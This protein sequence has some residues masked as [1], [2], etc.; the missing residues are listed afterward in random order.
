MIRL[1]P[2]AGQ[3]YTIR[4]CFLRINSRLL[5]HLIE[6][7]LAIRQND[8][9]NIHMFFM[10]QS[11]FKKSWE[12]PG[13]LAD[14]SPGEVT[15]RATEPLTLLVIAGKP[16]REPVVASGP[17]VMNIHEQITR[18]LKITGKVSLESGIHIRR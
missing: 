2:I 14:C 15:I 3:P 10:N 13:Q 4:R 16:L 17:F 11:L 8:T 7:S 5:L 9:G 6:S 12:N 1:K 18:P